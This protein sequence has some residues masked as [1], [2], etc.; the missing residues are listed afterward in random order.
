MSCNKRTKDVKI[1]ILLIVNIPIG[2]HKM[3]NLNITQTDYEILRNVYTDSE[4]EMKE[5]LLS[6]S[7]WTSADLSHLEVD[8]QI[9]NKDD[10]LLKCMFN[11]KTHIFKTVK[12]NAIKDDIVLI[13]SGSINL[14]TQHIGKCYRISDRSISY[15]GKEKTYLLAIDTLSESGNEYILPLDDNQYIVLEETGSHYK[16]N[17][18]LI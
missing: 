10:N 2:D 12:R 17:N 3:K 8:I 7:I 6:L 4:P 13:T 15:S 5:N 11:G 18:T 16:N 1:T 9:L 14:D